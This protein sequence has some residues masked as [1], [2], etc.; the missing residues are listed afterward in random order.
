MT[1]RVL[2]ALIVS[3]N[4]PRESC[5]KTCQGDRDDEWM[6][7]SLARQDKGDGRILVS[8]GRGCSSPVIMLSYANHVSLAEVSVTNPPRRLRSFKLPL[9]PAW[10]VSLQPFFLLVKLNLQ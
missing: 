4:K 10:V 5:G 1:Q 2:T 3:G 8:L 9:L 6:G 7:V